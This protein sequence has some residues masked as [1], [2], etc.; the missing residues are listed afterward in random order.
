MV[1]RRAFVA[2]PPAALLSSLLADSAHA[3][4]D[5]GD[6]T[7][8]VDPF[9]GTDGTGH[10]TPAASVPFGMVM[11]GPDR[12]NRG[13]SYSS[14]YQWRAP[15][16]LGFS[17]THISGAGIN[18]LGDVL[19]MPS[20]GRN[21]TLQTTDFSSVHDPRSESA[22]P[23]VYRITLP[24]H[25]VRVELTASTRVAVHR[26]TFARSGP[27]QVL[28]D[29][30]HGLHFVT[31]S[32]VLSSESAVDVA[33]GEITG[34]VHARNWVERQ[35]S[36]IVQFDRPIRQ[37]LR[38]PDQPESLEGA[39]PQA[40]RYLLSFE[41]PANRVMEVRVAL[42]TV[43][44]TGARQNLEEGHGRT[45]NDIRAAADAQWQ[46]LLGRLRI[47]ADAR[48]RRIFYSALY[49][50]CLHPSN[51][52]D[53]A[54]GG[55]GR[56]RG[57]RGEV[58]ELAE[59]RYDSTLSLWDTF[60]AVH[61]LHTLIAPERVRG[62]VDTFLAHHRQMGFLP[63]WT[64]WGR[65]TFT[66]IGNPALPVMAEAITKGFVDPALARDALRAM[67]ETSTQSRRG[68]P[69]FAQ[70]DWTLYDTHNHLPID[71]YAGGEA[72]SK[73]LEYGIGDDAVARIARQLGEQE[74]ANRFERRSRGWRH[75][76]D[77]NTQVMRGRSSTGAWRMP[78]DPL[79]AT[80]PMNNPGDYTEANAWQY[81]ATPALH[82][83]AGY[84]DL[85]GGPAAL[86]RW[87]DQFFGTSMPKNLADKHL[88]QE[89]MIGQLAHGNEPSHHI[90]WLYAF[91]PSPEK[92][93]ALVAR[94]AR[95][96][97]SD[98][99]DGI[100]G[101]DDCGQMGA[102]YV[103]AALGFYPVQPAS[104]SYVTGVPLVRAAQLWRAGRD[105]LSITP[106]R[107][108]GVSMDGQRVDPTSLPHTA[109]QTGARLRLGS[110]AMKRS[111]R[112]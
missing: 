100:I 6:V 91:T 58:I 60:R 82:D 85:L 25:G 57:P 94:I 68:V 11:P 101:N 7:Q 37:V 92:G 50:A 56:V 76:W 107:D 52:A 1:S 2:L 73:T 69:S 97:Y 89:A 4:L 42:S 22:R 36:F 53:L 12:G 30:H 43:D 84:R 106:G 49:R 62:Y 71:L 77:V 38:L 61:P 27:V 18:E 86:E 41:A 98:S 104:G 24:D 90:P 35:A 3:T 17:N 109:L 87:L 8:W 64:A 39:G 51:I 83:A 10:V 108:S 70:Q 54:P 80:S 29:L 31:G 28:V 55:R 67:V 75:L 23:G 34:T 88:G 112:G 47:D 13:W 46:T 110:A 105:P 32:R 111:S 48:T 102:W 33:R 45:F 9:I 96:F 66:M 79:I 21:W 16:T 95:E 103:F 65:E 14:G 40:P 63:L 74:I 20:A 26:W 72:V 44:V 93:H 15:R 78:F 81:T 99:P 59:P 5:G 19:L